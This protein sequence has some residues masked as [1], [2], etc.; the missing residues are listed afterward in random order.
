MGILSQPPN[1]NYVIRAECGKSDSVHYF[2]DFLRNSFTQSPLVLSK[3]NQVVLIC[4]LLP[5][6]FQIL[7]LSNFFLPL[8]SLS[9][10][11]PLNSQ[12]LKQADMFQRARQTR[13][14][15]AG[16]GTSRYPIGIKS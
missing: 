15:V 13:K 2:T 14:Q 4:L 9:L 16:T 12:I 3:F 10:F 8:I 5:F 7:N 11:L 1:A 6:N